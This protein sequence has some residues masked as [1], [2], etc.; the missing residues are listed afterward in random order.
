MFLSSVDVSSIYHNYYNYIF[1]MKYYFI[2]VPL[3]IYAVKI[4]NLI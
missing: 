4:T 2:L 1:T 3:F